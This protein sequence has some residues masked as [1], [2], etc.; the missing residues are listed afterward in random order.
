MQHFSQPFFLYTN[1]F[2]TK[3]LWRSILCVIAH[4][5][6]TQAGV[7]PIDVKGRFFIDSV[8]NEPVSTKL[9][10]AREY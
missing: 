2:K 9:I 4:L 10:C 8:T 5:L 6:V 3:M 7:N 1:T